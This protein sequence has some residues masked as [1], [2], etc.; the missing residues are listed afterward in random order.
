[1]GIGCLYWEGRRGWDEGPVVPGSPRSCPK[2]SV[3]LLFRRVFTV[4]TRCL[5]PLQGPRKHWQ[6]GGKGGKCAS[7]YSWAVPLLKRNTPRVYAHTNTQMCTNMISS[8]SQGWEGPQPSH[9]HLQSGWKCKTHGFLMM[10][11][12]LKMRFISC[13]L[14][15]GSPSCEGREMTPKRSI[16]IGAGHA[17]GWELSW[18]NGED[19]TGTH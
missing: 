7:C 12:G 16:K 19:C 1:M 4:R 8:S 6:M 15:T 2:G 14:I 10:E 13:Q 17:Q 5:V 11:L 9:L 3:N 18:N